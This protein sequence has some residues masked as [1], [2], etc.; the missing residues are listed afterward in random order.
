MITKRHNLA[1]RLIVKAISKCS[2]GG[3][4]THL[5]VGSRALLA[6]NDLQTPKIATNR[7]EPEWLFPRSIPA[8]HRLNLRHPDAILVVPFHAQASQAPAIHPRNESRSGVGRG[9]MGQHLASAP[10]S[11]ARPRINQPN[12]LT[13]DQRQIHLVE[14]K[15]YENTNEMRTN[16]RL[17][18]DSIKSSCLRSTFTSDSCMMNPSVSKQQPQSL[19][20]PFCWGWV[21]LSTSHT[22]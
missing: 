2:F 10:A 15:F 22:R 13:P 19:S 20:T 8:T 17:P 6:S 3:G 11:T 4:L 21:R 9:G 12:Q 14:I 5:D 16:L 18:N 1:C 7:T